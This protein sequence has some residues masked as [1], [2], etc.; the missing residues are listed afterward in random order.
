MPLRPQRRVAMDFGAANGAEDRTALHVTDDQPSHGYLA[1]RRSTRPVRGSRSSAS[2]PTV[3]A[4]SPRSSS[5][6]RGREPT[7]RFPRLLS[8]SKIV[9]PDTAAMADR[10]VATPRPDASVFTLKRT[11]DSAQRA[12]RDVLDASRG[13]S[14]PL[15]GEAE[16]ALRVDGELVR[17]AEAASSRASAEPASYR[18]PLTAARAPTPQGQGCRRAR[19]GRARPAE[20]GV[21]VCA[22]P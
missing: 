14:S 12:A 1:E 16:A 22:S 10:A 20:P 2:G 5:S 7:R 17:G 9:R 21:C 13:S 8:K 4:P 11:R 19:R 18:G 3:T 6:R 15:P